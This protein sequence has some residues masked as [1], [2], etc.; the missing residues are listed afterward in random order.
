MELLT[1]VAPS[2]R[3]PAPLLL[4]AKLF[5]ADG[6]MLVTLLALTADEAVAMT[7]APPPVGGIAV[8]S[9]NGVRVAT[10]IAWV[11]GGRVGLAFDATLD[12]TG[13]ER[14]LGMPGGPGSRA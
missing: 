11:D 6:K 7:E 4:S 12:T 9:R 5:C 1:Q 13:A 2:E 3:D 14:L 10:T 8:L